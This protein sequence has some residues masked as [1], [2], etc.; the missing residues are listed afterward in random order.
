[1]SRGTVLVC[2]DETP[3]ADLIAMYLDDAGYR[4]VRCETGE[5]ALAEA[6]RSSPCLAVVDVMLPGMDGFEVCRELRRRGSD[7][8][9]LFLTARDGEI[10]RVLGL[11]L[12]ADDYLTKPFSPRE[13]VARVKAIL[14]RM[15]ARPAA[16]DVNIAGTVIDA[17][18]REVRPQGGEPLTLTAKE[19]DL[20]WYLVEN[21]GLVVTREQI[22]QAVWGYDW[23]GETRTVDV[24]I[25]QIR[26]KLGG[27]IEVRTVWGVGY[28][29]VDV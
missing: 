16:Q 3:I 25:R 17:G 18:R 29:L 7:I 4:V 15:D 28:Q 11:E 23:V 1:M 9:L 24:H 20:L 19:F 2:E 22:V 6:G 13:L 14:R 26:K 21:R 27:C 12:G 10:D 8:P 5:E